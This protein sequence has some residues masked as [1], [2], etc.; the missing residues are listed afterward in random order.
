MKDERIIPD[1]RIPIRLRVVIVCAF[2]I[3]AALAV[4]L[5]VRFDSVFWASGFFVL[6]LIGIYA[7]MLRR[8]CPEC[9]GRLKPRW[10]DVEGTDQHRVYFD[11][12]HCQISWTDGKVYRDDA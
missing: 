11:C 3:V 6:T 8:F 7:V 12:P 4:W 1:P 9:R 10:K 2:C 5:A